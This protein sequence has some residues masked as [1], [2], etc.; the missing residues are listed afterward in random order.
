MNVFFGFVLSFVMLMMQ[1][2][3]SGHSNMHCVVIHLSTSIIMGNLLYLWKQYERTLEGTT[4]HVDGTPVHPVLMS[5]QFTPQTLSL[6]Q[7]CERWLWEIGICDSVDSSHC[8]EHGSNNCACNIYHCAI[9]MTFFV[10][11]APM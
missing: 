9:G 11:C 6:E 1:C 3:C 7:R 4:G 5:A 10:S 2:Y 8:S